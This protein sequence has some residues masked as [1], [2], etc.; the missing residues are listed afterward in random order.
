MAA[1][2]TAVEHRALDRAFVV[3]CS[4]AGLQGRL[5]LRWPVRTDIP[6][7]PKKSYRSHY[8]YLGWEDLKNPAIW[9]SLSLF[10]VLLRM[11]DY[12][13]LRDVL[14]WLLGWR[15]GRGWMP[16]DPV[17]FLLFVGWQTSNKWTRTQALHFLRDPHYADVV[18]RLG[19]ADGCF[20]TEGGV[21]YFLTTIGSHSPSGETVTVD[22]EGL[23]KIAEQR[24]NQLLRQS[25]ILLY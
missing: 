13:G 20:P 17:S 15:S 22:E 25:V 23:T 2:V 8:V 14:A 16:F 10:E 18:R 12:D 5:P 19:F 21:R 3:R 1:E 9:E 7:S 11:I 6:H 24:L 4:L